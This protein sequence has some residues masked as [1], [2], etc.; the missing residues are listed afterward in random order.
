MVEFNQKT[1]NAFVL[2]SRKPFEKDLT[3]L[4]KLP[5]VSADRE[6]T[7]EFEEAAGLAVK[8]LKELGA[9]AESV[10]TDGNPVVMA[11]LGNDSTHPTVLIYNH[12]DVQP[13]DPSEWEHDPFSLTITKD[14]YIGR[15]ATDDKGPALT[16]LYAVKY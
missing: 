1:L 10:A 8:M 3:S 5:T 7:K 2:K 9:E 14:R 4:V 12:L 6:R 15:G 16:A 13:A 11:S